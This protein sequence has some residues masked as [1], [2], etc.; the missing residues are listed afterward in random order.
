MIFLLILIAWLT[1]IAIVVNAC[2]GAARGDELLAEA[3]HVSSPNGGRLLGRDGPAAPGLR[4][5]ERPR[6]AHGNARHRGSRCP[7]GS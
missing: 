3:S 6:S 2:R 7:A 5:I 1:I 4:S